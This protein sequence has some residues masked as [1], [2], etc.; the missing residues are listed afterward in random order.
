LTIDSYRTPEAEALI[1][2]GRERLHRWRRR[3]ELL[4]NAVVAGTFA[5]TAGLIAA[6]APWQPT[7]SLENLILVLAVW[8]VVDSV[9]FPV[10]SAWTYP[11]MLVF[12]PALFLLP[13][14][15]VP[16]VAVGVKIAR[17]L[18]DH[19]SGRVPLSMLPIPFADS[20]Y[21]IGP[22]L[23]IVLA[24]AQ[25]FAWSYWPVYV[26]ALAAGLLF[27]A[28]SS[29]TL[30]W[31]G[32]G[33]SPRVNLPLLSWIYLVD[34][35]FAP[36]G[37]LIAAAAVRRPALVLLALSPIAILWLFA[38]ERRQRMDETL[39]LST[40]YRGTAMLLGDVVEADHHYTGA[41]SRDVVEMSLAVAD[42][43]GLD[44]TQRRN[45]EF[46]ALLHDVGKIHIPKE[47][48]NKP[49]KLDE[50][51]WKLMRSHTID[52]ERMLQQVGGLLATVGHI[53]RATHEHYGGGGYP[54]GL[55]GA[56]I[57]VEARI[58]CACDAYSA[59]TTDR[60]YRKAMSKQDA[61]AELRRCA[62]S[63]FDPRVVTAIEKLE[64]S[65]ILKRAEWLESLGS[66]GASPER[67]SAPARRAAAPI[68]PAAA[69]PASSP[70]VALVLNATAREALK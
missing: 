37:L 68:L 70:A 3:R 43:L 57:P 8:V 21:T 32:E 34:V 45:V 5:I 2:S 51:E 26:A 49:G 28:V 36:L 31:V 60:S 52:G 50:S 20:W 4:T 12:V 48:I 64:G 6:L 46:G 53:V 23:V 35:T 40:A 15:L 42:R 66:S 41:H 16:F 18:P 63:Q 44:P 67:P 54:D 47:I 13:T 25:H 29:I 22:V 30:D 59:M 55:A 69:A 24:G 38:R 61:L 58:V 62:G 19:L 27:D 9:K 33:I 14:P 11:T 17:R 10:A 1:V 7:F 65:A 39:A 56:A